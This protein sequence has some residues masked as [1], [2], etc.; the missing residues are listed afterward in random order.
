MPP[1]Q[2]R[3]FTL[4]KRKQKNF[5]DTKLIFL[6]NVGRGYAEIANRVHVREAPCAIC[7]H[8][9]NRGTYGSFYAIFMKL[10]ERYDNVL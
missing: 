6:Q 5:D 9:K 7:F 2:P 4:K 3:G 8:Q 10:N 1:G